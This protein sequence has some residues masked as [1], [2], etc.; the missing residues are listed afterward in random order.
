[1]EFNKIIK[2]NELTCS[3]EEFETYYNNLEIEEPVITGNKYL[4]SEK[5][6]NVTIDNPANGKYYYT[7]DFEGRTYLQAHAPFVGGFIAL[8]EDNIDSIIQEHKDKIIEEYVEGKKLQDT[9]EHF[10]N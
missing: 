5:Y 7:I 6:N 8:N 10:K 1:M 3:V 4:F 2:E 9:I